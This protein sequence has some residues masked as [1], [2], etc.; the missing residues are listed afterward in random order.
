VCPSKVPTTVFYRVQLTQAE[1]RL[2]HVRVPDF[3]QA[4]S[5]ASS[6]AEALRRASEMLLAVIDDYVRARQV[7]PEGNTA[8]LPGP[9][10]RVPALV[11]AKVALHNEM[12]RRGLRKSAMRQRLK[13]HRP[14]I[15]RLLDVRY[16]S[17]MEQVEKA[18]DALGLELVVAARPAS[19]RLV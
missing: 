8:P 19:R 7:I 13:W 4:R 10:V 18:F 6:K 12:R 9:C 16:A 17:K 1:S 3:P 11:A 14:Q 15:D 2:W 5:T